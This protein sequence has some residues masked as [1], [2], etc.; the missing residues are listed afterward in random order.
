MSSSSSSYTTTPVKVQDKG[1]TGACFD[2]N[3][4]KSDVGGELSNRDNTRR[5]WIKVIGLW[6][7][8]DDILNNEQLRYIAWYR[9]WKP[10]MGVLQHQH[11]VSSAYV[12]ALF[13]EDRMVQN[14]WAW[15]CRVV[16]R[17]GDKEFFLGIGNLTLVV[18]GRCV[19]GNASKRASFIVAMCKDQ[20]NAE[21]IPSGMGDRLASQKISDA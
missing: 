6:R 11:Q 10:T 15:D 5:E 7:T 9:W 1:I 16:V 17:S 4:K 18:P 3:L 14:R 20:W 2:I 13:Y 12:K 19:W 8:F 21:N